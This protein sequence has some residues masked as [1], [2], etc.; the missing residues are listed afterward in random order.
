MKKILTTLFLSLTFISFLHASNFDPLL[1]SRLQNLTDSLRL[2]N[3]I[4]GISVCV[5]H[6]QQG[7]WQGV[8]GISHQGT[9]IDSNMLF[10][11]GSNTKLFTG[12]LMLK[13]MLLS[14]IMASSRY[15]S[16]SYSC[17]SVL[18]LM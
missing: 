5:L 16:C 8:S 3:N 12:V 10:G 4:K 2:A 15:W 1:A 11:I 17:C 18:L 7:R 13:L 14:S 9:P 6:P